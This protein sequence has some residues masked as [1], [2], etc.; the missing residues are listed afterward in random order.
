MCT[1][2]RRDDELLA[3]LGVFTTE[4][5]H[6]HAHR[7]QA[8]KTWLAPGT[9]PP[10]LDVK[11]VAR[12]RGASHR[13][14]K[15]ADTHGDVV[16]LNE[17]SELSRAHG[18]LVTL[19]A[20]LECVAT[21]WPNAELV[22]KAD[23]DVMLML[24]GVAAHLHGSQAEL[25]RIGGVGAAPPRMLWGLLESFHWDAATHRPDGF[26]TAYVYQKDCMQR[27]PQLK[28]TRS[29]G[30]FHFAKGACFFFS[31]AFLPELLGPRVRAEVRAAITAAENRTEEMARA[32]RRLE[33][34]DA[35]PWED[36]LLGYALTTSVSSTRAGGQWAAG[37]NLAYV[38]IGRH[39]YSEEWFTHRSGLGVAPATLIMH[40]RR[41]NSESIARAHRWM[42]TNHCQPPAVRLA[43]LA[44]HYT[45]CT[46]ARWRRC[47]VDAA[48]FME[49][50]CSTA[51]TTY[52]F[53]PV[54]SARPVAGA[55]GTQ[56]T[57]RGMRGTVATRN[58]AAP[59]VEA[60]REGPGVSLVSLTPH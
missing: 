45:S 27:N 9:W 4:S 41:K 26:D 33:N 46:G 1:A 25:R 2:Q 59:T 44:G 28:F 39:I 48:P 8:R 54:S 60:T 37:S 6:S 10:E 47:A 52:L 11:F 14:W 7:R 29:L 55:S 42:R 40:N 50:N 53:S 19:M 22:G 24:G 12:G 31:S 36:V 5:A 49:S 15:E 51:I 21:A 58:S 23:D 57:L 43:C 38:H 16:F 17:S 18:P 56:P 13:I 35:L 34:P 3:V 30:P 32:L 20:W